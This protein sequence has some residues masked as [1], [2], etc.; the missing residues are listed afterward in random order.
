[1]DLRQKLPLFKGDTVTFKCNFYTLD[2]KRWS[3]FLR[4]KISMCTVGRDVFVHLH[5]VWAHMC[6]PVCFICVYIMYVPISVY[7][8]VHVTVC[9][10]MCV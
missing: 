5:S 10:Y 1:M 9:I 2:S 4:G 7:M 3:A 8:C 6:M